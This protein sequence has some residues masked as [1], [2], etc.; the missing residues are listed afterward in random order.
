MKRTQKGDGH[1]EKS[2]NTTQRSRQT[3]KSNSNKLN[4]KAAGLSVLSPSPSLSS[5]SA[6]HGSEAHPD[7][8]PPLGQRGPLGYWP[9]LEP[10]AQGVCGRPRSPSEARACLSQGWRS[11]PL[12][13]RVTFPQDKCQQFCGETGPAWTFLRS[14][15]RALAQPL[16]T[17][18]AWQ[19]RHPLPT[20]NVN[21]S[22]PVW[23]RWVPVGPLPPRRLYLL[24]M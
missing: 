6:N 2:G 24:P 1:K 10:R 20:P 13:R 16:G 22:M 5:P 17:Y 4:S 15:E 14:K 9:G 21:G 19:P 18:T 12:Q 23:A 11:R 3:R 7:S 8:P